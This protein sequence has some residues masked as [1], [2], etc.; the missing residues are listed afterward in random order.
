MTLARS[1]CAAQ[2][3]GWTPSRPSATSIESNRE[4]P[5]GLKYLDGVLGNGE[6]ANR[7]RRAWQQ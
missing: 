2:A 4:E 6:G 5:S 1:R 3:L 7:Y